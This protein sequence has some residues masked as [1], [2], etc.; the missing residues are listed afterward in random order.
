MTKVELINLL[1]YILVEWIKVTLTIEQYS[2]ESANKENMSSGVDFDII[3][4]L[5]FYGMAPLLHFSL[6]SLFVFNLLLS[7]PHVFL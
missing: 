4:P 5:Q 3:N 7:F 1:G 2:A 6:C